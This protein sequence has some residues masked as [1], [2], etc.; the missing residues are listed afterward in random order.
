MSDQASPADESTGETIRASYL[1][2]KSDKKQFGTGKKYRVA[3]KRPAEILSIDWPA[4]AE[5]G[6]PVEI[7]VV[8]RGLSEGAELTL[9]IVPQGAGETDTL[10]V[11]VEAGKA[12]TTWTRS[13]APSDPPPASRFVCTARAGKATKTSTPLAFIATLQLRLCTDAGEVLPNVAWTMLI[14]REKQ[15]GVSDGEGVLICPVHPATASCELRFECDVGFGPEEFRR[16]L[17]IAP[18]P[19]A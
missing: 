3:F 18:V 16:K 19:A 13:F 14:G 4:R 6:Y 9:E 7:E 15:S 2:K 5:A 11:P 17:E 8:T 1:K 12:K 10:T